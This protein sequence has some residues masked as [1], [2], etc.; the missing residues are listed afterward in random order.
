MRIETERININNLKG[1]DVIITN[2]DCYM[3]SLDMKRFFSLHKGTVLNVENDSLEGTISSFGET[4]QE[5]IPNNELVIRR[6]V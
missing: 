4:V 3:L 5:I 1:G 2:H 6:D